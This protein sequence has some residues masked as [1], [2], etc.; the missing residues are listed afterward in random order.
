[1]DQNVVTV[2]LISGDVTVDRTPIRSGGINRLSALQ[3][4]PRKMD[5]AWATANYNTGPVGGTIVQL[6]VSSSPWTV[7]LL[8]S[9]NVAFSDYHFDFAHD[10]AYAG[11]PS[12]A[13]AFDVHHGNPQVG[14]IAIHGTW[15]YGTVFPFIS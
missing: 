13:D 8:T 5:Q 3:F 10:T 11:S 15:N 7:S 6:D 2:S 1:M 9:T 12:W 4:N 14:V